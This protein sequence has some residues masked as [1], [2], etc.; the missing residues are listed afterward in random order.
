MGAAPRHAQSTRSAYDEDALL[1]IRVLGADI[2]GPLTFGLLLAGG[3]QAYRTDLLGQLT[4]RRRGRKGRWVYDR[5]LGGKRVWVPAES[6]EGGSGKLPD[7]MSDV[8]FSALAAVAATKAAAGSGSAAQQ[9]AAH[10]EPPAW[11]E[12]PGFLPVTSEADR[13]RRRAEAERILRRIEASKNRGEDYALEDILALRAACMSAGGA[14]LDARTVGGRDAIYRTAVEAGIRS[15]VEPGSVDLG[16]Y[17]PI[18]LAAGVASDVSL[19]ERRAVTVLKGLVAGAC[20]G[21]VVEVGGPGRGR[22]V[23]CLA[24]GGLVSRSGARGRA[25]FVERRID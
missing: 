17:S 15:C 11:W 19:D 18:R 16:D 7:H 22:R 8:D 6:E 3:W 9:A 4:G 12:R 10:Y 25:R 24:A 2:T 14:S 13:A 1:S 23:R 21:R 20:R 5:G